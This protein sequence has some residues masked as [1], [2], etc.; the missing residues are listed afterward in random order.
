MDK[1]LYFGFTFSDLVQRYN[2]LHVWV[3]RRMVPTFDENGEL[4]SQCI[5][6]GRLT[7]VWLGGLVN[8]QA[9]LTAMQQEKAV[10]A[11]TTVDQVG[12]S[13]WQVFQTFSCCYCLSLNVCFVNLLVGRQPVCQLTI[14]VSVSRAVLMDFCC[15]QVFQAFLCV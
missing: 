13:C 2:Q 10:L 9:L 7:S 8:P 3:K 12:F 6:R 4:A 1:L 15:L 11:R 5:A 14:N